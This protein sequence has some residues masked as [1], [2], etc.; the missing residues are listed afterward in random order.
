MLID[1]REW[2]NQANLRCLRKAFDI[3]RPISK[4]LDYL[5]NLKTL[6]LDEGLK[7]VFSSTQVA[8][9]FSSAYSRLIS[10]TISHRFHLINSVRS[11]LSHTTSLVYLKTTATHNS[12]IDWLR[13]ED[14][15][16][17]Q[18]TSTEKFWTPRDF[19]AISICWR[20]C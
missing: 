18:T 11:L 14:L 16:R 1:L 13:W 6:V 19:S 9:V 20:D 5:P 12:M 7:R 2:P 4:L 17:N 3:Q 10:L 15:I 8:E